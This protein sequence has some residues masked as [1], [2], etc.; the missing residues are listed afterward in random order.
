MRGAVTEQ[1]DSS[2]AHGCLE[3]TPDVCFVVHRSWKSK[4]TGALGAT[5]RACKKIAQGVLLA[6]AL[7]AA[8]MAILVEYGLTYPAG[9]DTMYP[10]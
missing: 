7:S 4:W 9:D 1:T 5:W 10:T 2:E 8:C 3:I 6:G